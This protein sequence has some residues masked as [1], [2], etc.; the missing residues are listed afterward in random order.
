MVNTLI[1]GASRGIG[2]AVSKRLAEECDN[3]FLVAKS[4]SKLTD[5][6]QEI[7]KYSNCKPHII[8]CDL[9]E[10]SSSK[11][12]FEEV[13]KK[14]NHLD[15]VFLNAGIYKEGNATDS[16][17]KDLDSQ[18]KINVYSIMNNVSALLNLIE[19]SN[20]RR[21]VVTGST[22]GSEPYK[23]GAHY[24]ITKWAL[25]GYAQN[26]RQELMP[27]K[28]GVTYYASGATDT[29]MWEGVNMPNGKLIDPK[30]HGELIATLLRL[31]PNIAI[32]EIVARPILGDPH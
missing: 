6:A 7:K 27:K 21:I 20:I 2:R 29:D 19:K 23:E 10:N 17:T 28:I 26:L 25:R 11:K 32:E 14:V 8:T 31:G 3:I 4:K 1:T 12:I 13:S 5:V 22:A 18:M 15:L 30:D 16:A 24:S 9:L